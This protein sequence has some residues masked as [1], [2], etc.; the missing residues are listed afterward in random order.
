MIR[1]NVF[2]LI[3]INYNICIEWLCWMVII[4]KIKQDAYLVDIWVLGNGDYRVG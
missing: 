1:L 3:A 2:R 4:N